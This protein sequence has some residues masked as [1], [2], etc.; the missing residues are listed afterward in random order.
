M[1]LDQI[2]KELTKICLLTNGRSLD[3]L[4][5]ESMVG[6]VLKPTLYLQEGNNVFSLAL[7]AE[8]SRPLI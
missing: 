5:L 2:E 7:P 8:L 1:Q 4:Q 6:I 3:S